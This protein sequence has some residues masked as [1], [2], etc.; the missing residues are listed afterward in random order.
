MLAENGYTVVSGLAVGC[1]TLGHEGALDVDGT[2]VAVL[3]TPIGAPVYPRQN[4]D[5]AARIVDAGG[6]LVSEYGPDVQLSNRQ[7]V[8]NLVARDEWQPALSDGVAAI[9]TSVGGGTRH[10][11]EHALKTG[12]PLAVFDYRENERL[13]P[14]FETDPWFG[15]N[16]KYLTIE[17]GAFPIFG[18]ETIE[19]FKDAMDAYRL[20]WLARTAGSDTVSDGDDG[21]LELTFR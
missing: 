19:P 1:D 8:S 21:Q 14:V 9:E 17:Y 15:G 11:V 10:A 13:R 3:P 20:T 16:M 2:T 12:V 7:L 5:L 4:Q 18:P 6:A